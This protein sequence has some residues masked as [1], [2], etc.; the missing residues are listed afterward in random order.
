MAGNRS[1]GW[2]SPR[3]RLGVLGGCLVAAL[4][5]PAAAD[6]TQKGT[7]HKQVKH[8]ETESHKAE[9]KA[10]TATAKASRGIAPAPACCWA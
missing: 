1:S 3:L 6:T 5:V 9:G 2:S 7:K 4:C 10:N 8:P